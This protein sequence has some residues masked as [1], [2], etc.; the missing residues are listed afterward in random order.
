MPSA[1]DKTTTKRPEALD[2]D[3]EQAT[4]LLDERGHHH[5]A[6]CVQDIALLAERLHKA[7]IGA[8]DEI[9]TILRGQHGGWDQALARLRTYIREEV[10]RT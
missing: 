2:N 6:G 10:S 5:L 9:D 3:W 8:H 4:G 1:P 7:L